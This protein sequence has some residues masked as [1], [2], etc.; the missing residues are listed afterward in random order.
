MSPWVTACPNCGN[1]STDLWRCDDRATCGKELRD[2]HVTLRVYAD[3]DDPEAIVADLRRRDRL[4]NLPGIARDRLDDAGDREDQHGDDSTDAVTGGAVVATAGGVD[5][6][7][8]SVD[9]A[10]PTDET[11][12]TGDTDPVTSGDDNDTTERESGGEEET[13][14]DAPIVA[15]MAGG[16]EDESVCPNCGGDVREVEVASK[17]GLMCRDDCDDFVA[18]WDDDADGW[19]RRPLDD[20]G[21]DG[22]LDEQRRR[23]DHAHEREQTPEDQAEVTAWT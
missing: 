20:D 11:A 5:A 13:D 23:E 8:T 6:A 17:R 16:W 18:V 14:A 4:G 15:A 1:L 9:D 21:D 22:D 7:T 19:R 12:L 3:P 2:S 10:E